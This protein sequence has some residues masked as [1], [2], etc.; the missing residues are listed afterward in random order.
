MLN[1]IRGTKKVAMMTRRLTNRAE[2]LFNISYLLEWINRIRF[3][4]LLFAALIT[5]V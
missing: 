3:M 4:L 2:K 1:H 5:R